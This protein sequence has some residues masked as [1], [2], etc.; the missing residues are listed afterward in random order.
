MIKFVALLKTNFSTNLTYK[1]CQIHNLCGQDWIKIH[2]GTEVQIKFVNM[3]CQWYSS[4][5]DIFM[6]VKTSNKGYV[7]DHI[8]P[9]YFFSRNIW[10]VALFINQ[11][12]WTI[13]HYYI[14]KNIVKWGFVRFVSMRQLQIS[15][16]YNF[17]LHPI[18][19]IN[20]QRIVSADV[21]KQMLQLKKQRWINWGI[22][23]KLPII[24][25]LYELCIEFLSIHNMFTIVNMYHLR[26]I[27][28]NL[29]LHYIIRNWSLLDSNQKSRRKKVNNK[30]YRI[31]LL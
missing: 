24:I 21:K 25:H 13:S 16:F 3:Y 31:Y 27:D 8:L 29:I 10:F 1:T 11:F 28:K 20:V 17:Y 18:R 7:Y 23:M 26:F 14:R 30:S 5:L 15:N 2:Q 4:K 12:W 9:L 19:D 6:I 22:S